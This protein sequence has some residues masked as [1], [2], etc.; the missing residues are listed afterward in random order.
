MIKA[1]Y[2]ADEIDRIKT[3]IPIVLFLEARGSSLKQAGSLFKTRCLFHDDHDPSL[4]VYPKDNHYHCFGCG[5]HGD[6]I[7]L[8]M[9]LDGVGF[10]EACHRLGGN[11]SA[12]SPPRAAAF[13]NHYRKTQQQKE[14]EEKQLRSNAKAAKEQILK[15]FAW[16]LEDILQDS[17]TTLGDY[18]SPEDAR[19][20]IVT[21]FDPHSTI[22]IGG[23]Y[24]SGGV[25]HS[26]HFQKASVWA[27]L[28]DLLGGRITSSIFRSGEYRRKASQVIERPYIVIE[29]DEAIGKKPETEEEKT[30]NRL[31]N[32]ALIRWCRDG[33][34]M[35]LVAVVDT[36]NKS[37]HGWFRKPENPRVCHELEVIATDLGIDGLLKS[38]VQ[39]VRL[40]GFIHEKSGRRSRLLWLKA[41]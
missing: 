2:P 31:A 36:G 10:L 22:W 41:L 37:L 6:V 30:Q 21:L 32:A 40:P 26:A 3:Q 38:A 14:D 34:R 35:E 11:A 13:S 15:E 12:S 19:L 28:P 9:R 20:M 4:F 16:S 5:E 29:A 27:N 8:L 39:P 24:D 25:R 17:P 18:P 33:L 23:I 7:S 1:F